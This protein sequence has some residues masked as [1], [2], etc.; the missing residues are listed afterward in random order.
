MDAMKTETGRQQ[1][2]IKNRFYET[3]ILILFVIKDAP[4]HF[5]NVT[6]E[7]K[8]HVSDDGHINTMKFCVANIRHQYSTCTNKSNS[9]IKRLSF[10][11]GI[12]L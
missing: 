7:M 2:S 8:K 12:I 4:D 3:E 6:D 10:E 9:S 5:E 11:N 1:K